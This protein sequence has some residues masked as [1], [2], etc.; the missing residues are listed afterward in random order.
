M[1]LDSAAA[2][3]GT[4]YAFDGEGTLVNVNSGNGFAFTTQ[5]VRFRFQSAAHH[6]RYTEPICRSTMQ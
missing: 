5:A 1:S 4:S 6:R 2:L 3:P